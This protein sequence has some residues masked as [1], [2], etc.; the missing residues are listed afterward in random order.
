MTEID[1]EMCRKAAAECIELARIT[2]DPAKKETLLG[3]AQEWLKLA[4]ANN[5]VEFGRLIAS[6]N[7]GQMVPVQRQPMQQQQQQKKDDEN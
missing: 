7:Q 1:R 3:R 6:L 5:D 2:A 4:Y